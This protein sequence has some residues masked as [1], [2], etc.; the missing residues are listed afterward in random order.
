MKAISIK[1]RQA[2][3]CME[4]NNPVLAQGAEE[5][6]ESPHLDRTSTASGSFMAR[7]K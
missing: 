3:F 6:E 7:P 1:A 4:D 5:L 2:F